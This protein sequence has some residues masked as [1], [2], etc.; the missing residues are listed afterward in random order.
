MEPSSS[1]NEAI[2]QLLARE[3]DTSP[4]AGAFSSVSGVLGGFSITLVV[5]ALTPGTIASNSGKD[6]I[7]A[8]VLLSAGLYIYSSGIFANSISYKDEKVKQKVFKSALVLFH[9]S[10]LLLSV[11]LLLL[12]FQFPLLYAARI[13]AM[14]IVFFA[15]VVAAINFF[16]K[17]SGSISSILE[18]ILASVS[19]G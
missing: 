11:G 5:L 3:N 8:L 15:F 16:C 10:N 9:L 1:L 7:V 2:L 19:S 12:T 6:W 4:T 17:L 18:S 14:I 13:A